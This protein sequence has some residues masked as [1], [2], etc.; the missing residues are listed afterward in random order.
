MAEW[1]KAHAWKA[2]IRATVSRV[3]IPLPP[4]PDDFCL[5]PGAAAY[6]R[7]EIA[8]AQYSLLR[9]RPC[10]GAVERSCIGAASL[11]ETARCRA[12][13]ICPRSRAPSNRA[14]NWREID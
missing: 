7:G 6:D 3:R 11:R 5:E 14:Q 2:C 13:R 9:R 12:E 4:L 8:A 1:L 10:G